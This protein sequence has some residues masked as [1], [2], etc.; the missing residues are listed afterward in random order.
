MLFGLLYTIFQVYGFLERDGVVFSRSW[1]G[2]GGGVDE[3]AI[4]LVTERD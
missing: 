4:C 2:A 3:I 1:R